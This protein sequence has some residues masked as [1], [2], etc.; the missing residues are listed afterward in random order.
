MTAIL[1]G[2]DT[3]AEST[4]NNPIKEK[5]HKP[6]LSMVNLL[7]ILLIVVI[8]AGGLLYLF[9][10]SLFGGKPNEQAAA[11]SENL[12]VTPKKMQPG[13]NLNAQVNETLEIILQ[14]TAT[15]RNAA[16]TLRIKTT[17]PQ[18]HRWNTLLIFTM[19]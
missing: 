17:P 11:I 5:S 4:P 8:S 9:K 1:K 7:L 13:D 10:G 3:I 6:K 2:S 14:H 19:E 18:S 15:A 16:S 12:A